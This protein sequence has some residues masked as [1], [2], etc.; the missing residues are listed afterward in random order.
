MRM[1]S[2]PSP[3]TR[4]TTGT[5]TDRW[6]IASAAL[7][8]DAIRG[9]AEGRRVAGDE[10]ERVG[11]AARRHPQ[12]EERL[13]QRLGVRRLRGSEAAV[14][15]STHPRAERSAARAR[16]GSQAG[17]AFRDHHAHVAT[18][19]AF[20]ADRRGRRARHRPLD[21]P[22]ER[23]EQLPAIDRAA[24]QLE[25]DLHVLRD[26]RGVR[27]RVDEPGAGVDGPDVF[28]DVAAV[29][30]RL[31]PARRR[32]CSDRHQEARALADR[33]QLFQLF[34]GGNRT[35]DEGDVVRAVVH[36][37]GRLGEVRDRDRAG[38]FEQRVLG[39]EQLEL[40]AVAR[41]HL[42]HGHAGGLRRA[43]S[44]STSSSSLT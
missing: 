8:L 23:R 3:S 12:I 32:A 38:Q 26:R 10:A 6:V 17:L 13:R 44:S 5:S 42:E 2:A 19:L 14:A 9:F 43:H 40:A 39:V 29:A 4:A 31:H 16:D 18:A 37:R 30:E 34:R 28:V 11:D 36:R 41:R 15:A 20:D 1:C 22:R 35:L 25:I 7:P 33:S 24:G 21:Q 27:E